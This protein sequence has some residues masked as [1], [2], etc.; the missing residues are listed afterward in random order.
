MQQPDSLVGQVLG[1]YRIIKQIGYGGTATVFLA[2]D[3]NL[4]R[5]VAVKVFWPRPGETRD[6]LK[7]FEREARVLAKLDHPNILPVFDYGEQ[8]GFAYLITPYLSGGSLKEM[9]QKRKV[10]PPVEVLRMAAPILNALQYASE[11]RL[12]HRDIKPGNLLFKADGSLVLADFGL[13]KVFVVEGENLATHTASETGPAVTGTPEYMSPEQIQGKATPLSDI[14]SFGIV[15]YEMLAGQRPFVSTNVLS[16]LM[17]QVNE[18]PRSLRELNPYISPQLDAAVLRA[19]EKDPARRYQ[20]P[21]EFLQAL[22]QAGSP[23]MA[24][25]PELNGPTV[26][27]N[28]SAPP[29]ISLP[30]NPPSHPGNPPSHPGNPPSHPGFVSNAPPINMGAQ[31]EQYPPQQTQFAQARTYPGPISNPGQPPNAGSITPVGQNWAAPAAGANMGDSSPR[32]R[33]SSRLPLLLVAISLLIIASL[34]LAVVLTPLGQQ[35]FGIHTGQTPT[36]T[37]NPSSTANKNVTP[38]STALLS[39]PPTIMTCPANGTGRAPVLTG[40]SLGSAP[41]LV[42]FVNEFQG[43]TSTFGTLK[44][45]D[46]ITGTKTEIVKIPN[47]RID[48][49]QLSGNGQWILF[50]A[51]IAGHVKLAVVRMDGQGLQTLACA[52]AGTRIS[53]PQWSVDQKLI[54]FDV[55]PNTGGAIIYLLVVASGLLQ[56][57]LTPPASGLAYL[58]RTWLDNTRVLMVGYVPNSDAPAQNIYILDTTLGPNQQSSNLQQFAAVATFCWNFDSSFDGKTIFFNQCTPG[59]PEGSST[60]AAQSTVGGAPASQVFSS[61]TLAIS[62]VRVFD[63]TD[64]FLLATTS[65]SALGVS[66]DHSKDGLY[67][68]ATDGSNN[69]IPLVLASNGLT[70]ALNAYSQYYWSNVSRDQSLYA[71]EEYGTSGSN[72][73]YTILYGSMNGGASTTIA[74]IGGTELEVAGWTTM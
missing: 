4:G 31:Q 44:R 6:F 21:L 51:H 29:A 7:R 71:L 40:M 10:I 15:L 16:V 34:V 60:V 46:T 39:A 59:N 57:E 66:G 43:N 70:P 73:T 45:Y 58:P 38:S 5:E 25:N 74:S 26:A 14:Y 30:G 19:L 35:L 36:V 49:A 32:N 33:R 62:A 1:H 48:S 47:T 67:K 72:A 2:E 12:I 50:S 11:R 61:S 41:N 24:T 17:Q 22:T 65:N 27:T 28:W 23:G 56:T 8:N 68:I 18:Q 9:L 20:R 13:V 54:V 64:A 55:S 3:V 42:Y 37:V 53:S 69:V 52:P 63:K